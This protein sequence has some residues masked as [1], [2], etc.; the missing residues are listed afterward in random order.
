MRANAMT[1]VETRRT[2]R[3]VREVMNNPELEVLLVPQVLWVLKVL[4]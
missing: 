1:G 2:Q 3:R 4:F